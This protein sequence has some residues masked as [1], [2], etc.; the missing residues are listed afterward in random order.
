MYAPKITRALVAIAAAGAALVIS[1]VP[2]QTRAA[3]DDAK[4]DKKMPS[5]PALQKMEPN[6]VMKM[7]DADKS[8]FVT[9][10]EFVKFYEALYERLDRDKDQQL[11][12][13]EFTDRG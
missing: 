9:R 2:S 12:P 4:K 8:G 6:D 3:A 11:K 13:A 7:M 5:Y 10:E 1:L